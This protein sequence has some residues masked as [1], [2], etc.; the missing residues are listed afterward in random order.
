MS[1]NKLSINNQEQA[2]MNTKIANLSEMENVLSVK[3]E[4]NDG[5][6]SLFGRFGLGN[7]LRHL[8]LDK[9]SGVNAVTLI[10]SLCLFRINGVS[11]L[12]AYRRRFNGLL[13]TGKNCF[14]RMMLRPVMD[15]RRLLLSMAGH[16]LVILRKEKA[17]RTDAPDAISLTTPYWKRPAVILRR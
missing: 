15:W 2:V 7:Q 12:G 5:I 6:I 4:I 16:F 9:S 11:I 14:Y 3:S 17:E 10:V 1:D 8:S 13:D